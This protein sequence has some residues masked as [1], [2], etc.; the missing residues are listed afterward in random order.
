MTSVTDSAGDNTAADEE[1]L[2]TS[3]TNEVHLAGNNVAI[4]MLQLAAEVYGPDFETKFDY[5]MHDPLAF[6]SGQGRNT[7]GTVACPDRV[8]RWGC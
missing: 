3:I 5:L 1:A 8:V 6:E 2:L 4:E 7:G